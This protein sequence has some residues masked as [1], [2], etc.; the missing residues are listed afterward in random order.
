M[1]ALAG[2]GAARPGNLAAYEPHRVGAGVPQRGVTWAGC[3]H[4]IP[5]LQVG[6]TD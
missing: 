3:A 6:L 2:V 1:V 4:R 5:L